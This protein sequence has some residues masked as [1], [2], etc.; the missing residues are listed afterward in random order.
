MT[1]TSSGLGR[2]LPLAGILA[3]MGAVIVARV[4]FAAG[5]AEAPAAQASAAPLPTVGLTAAV[6]P[7]VLTDSQRAAIRYMD[8]LRDLGASRSPMARPE[9]PATTPPK[10]GTVAPAPPPDNPADDLTLNSLLGQGDR[11]VASISG[12]LYRVGG[13]V[14][15]GW[16]LTAVDVRARRVTLTHTDGREC[17]LE[18]RADD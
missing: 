12:R 6:A 16:R 14:A 13:E 3:P 9:P 17:T 5:P 4:F 11:A 7:P 1:P 8:S 15:S 10:L 18:R 2:Y